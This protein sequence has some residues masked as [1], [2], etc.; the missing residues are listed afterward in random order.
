MQTQ[1]DIRQAITDRLV[2]AL[3]TTDN[4]PWRRPWRA[5]GPRLPTNPVTGRTYSGINVITRWLT[6]QEKNYPLDVWASYRQWAS[7]GAQVKKGERAERIVYYSQVERRGADEGGVEKIETFPLLKTW[8]VFNVSQVEGAAVEQFRDLPPAVPF[9]DENRTE[10]D[11]AVAATEADVR[12]GGDRAYYR[13]L[14]DDFV[15]V[16]H[17]ERFKSFAAYAETVLHEVGGHW[18]EHRLGWSGS[19]ALGELRAE[20]AACFL[21]AAL[22]IPDGG[23][24]TNHAKYLESWLRALGDD[25]R[26]IFRA[27]AAASRAAEYFLSFSRPQEAS[28]IGVEAGS[29]ATAA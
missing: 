12:H 3:R 19:Y 18:T 23:D 9:T 20:I 6:A 24:L 29:E 25:P 11:R 22:H 5:T 1:S 16:P 27:A 8:T 13:R 17:E 10:F 28:D 26:V 2:A 15:R 21:A 4:I 7:A 14:P